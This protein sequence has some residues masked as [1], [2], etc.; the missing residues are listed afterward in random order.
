[1]DGF[2]KGEVFQIQDTILFCSLPAARYSRVRIALFLTLKLF[3][4]LINFLVFL[5]CFHQVPGRVDG[6]WLSIRKRLA[7]GFEAFWHP[8]EQPHLPPSPCDGSHA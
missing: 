7:F 8:S 4:P 6:K 2:Y 3:F 5:H 1:M